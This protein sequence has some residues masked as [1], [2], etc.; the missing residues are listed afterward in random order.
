M[1]QTNNAIGLSLIKVH[2]NQRFYRVKQ[3]QV[4][5]TKSSRQST[6]DIPG[7]N[8]RSYPDYSSYYVSLQGTIEEKIYQRQINKQSLG[9]SIVD[10]VNKQNVK[11]SKDELKV[12]SLHSQLCHVP[13]IGLSAV[14]RMGVC[15]VP[16]IGP[17]S[18][19][20]MG[21]WHVR[22]I[23]LSSVRRMAVCHVPVIGLPSVRRMG[24]WHV[25]VIGLP[26]VRR[27][28]VWHV[29]VIGLSSPAHAIG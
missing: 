21:V 22:V 8:P 5:E 6:A 2:G 24:V 9:N 14:R 29:P 19:R 12:R 20:R 11:F 27:M 13:V 23:G 26:S 1:P 16:V 28:G 7:Q 10:S 17:P 25:P 4:S 18:V 3:N 15:H